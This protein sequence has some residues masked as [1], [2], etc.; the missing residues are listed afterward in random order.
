M[1][2]IFVTLYTSKTLKNGEHPI[3]MRVIKNRKSKYISLGFS[4]PLN[5][6]DTDRN[7]PKRKHPFY[8]EIILLIDKKKS[9]A[10]KLVFGMETDEEGY[11]AEELKQTIVK[12]KRS[13]A[14]YVL[15]YFDETIKNLKTANRL[16]YA[17]VF[18]NTK[19]S[20]KKFKEGKDFQFNDIT[21]SFLVRYEGWFQSR[22]V[23]PNSIFVFMRTL[24]TFINYAKRDGYV[25]KDYDPF[26]DFSFAKYRRIKT[27][28]RAIAKEDIIKIANLELETNTSL[29]HSRNIFL[30]SYYCRGINFIDIAHLKWT[31]IHNNRLEYTRRKTNEL[32]SMAILEPA[33]K[34]LDYYFEKYRKTENGFIFPI[35]NEKHATAE[36]KEYRIDKR[37]TKTN[38]DLKEIAQKAEIDETLTTYV[39]RHT[40]ATVLKK[41]GVSTALISEMM[42][43]DS[44]QTTKIY[45]DSFENI[46]LD[47]ANKN[48][49]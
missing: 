3:M 45:L 4:S 23:K 17:E 16:G 36:S 26:K 6:W 35:L 41:S 39:A 28:K 46:V 2:S 32:F 1:S 25:N 12:K 20:L 29:F 47:E 11:S 33:Q 22:G 31:D 34:I 24:K 19:N 18:T 9:D 13:G 40:Y 48:L 44:E 21:H 7:L 42:G 8:N 43:H 30:F 38:K 37:I 5:L 27:K 10:T 15:E 14:A 49:L